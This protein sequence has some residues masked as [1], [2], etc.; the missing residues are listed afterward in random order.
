[1]DPARMAVTLSMVL[2]LAGIGG[3]FRACG[4]LARSGSRAGAG[5]VAIPRAVPRVVVHPRLTTSSSAGRPWVSHPKR[6][7]TRRQGAALGAF[8]DDAARGTPRAA[9]R[10]R[11]R[12]AG[13][14]DSV[15]D[16][17]LGNDENEQR[18]MA[19]RRRR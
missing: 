14:A 11:G 18:P 8:G 13:N 5:V 19:P 7:S 4:S 10:W 3:A 1:M 15:L 6:R 9:G 16:L 12:A 2:A 17:D